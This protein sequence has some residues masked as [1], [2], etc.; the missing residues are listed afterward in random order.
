M[1]SAWGLSWAGAWGGSWGAVSAGG[2]SES[3]GSGGKR[4]PRAPEMWHPHLADPLQSSPIHVGQHNDA[5][6][7][8]ILAVGGM[9]I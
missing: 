2:S 7:A 6:A 9:A 4:K 1:A 5:M 8:A 3:G